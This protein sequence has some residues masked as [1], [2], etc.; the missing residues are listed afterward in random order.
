MDNIFGAYGIIDEILRPSLN[1]MLPLQGNV[2]GLFHHLIFM[3]L[4]AHFGS[5]LTKTASGTIVVISKVVNSPVLKEAQKIDLILFMAQIRSRNLD[6][7][8]IFFKI[9]WSLFVAVSFHIFKHN[10]RIEDEFISQM[11]STVVTYLVITCQ[12]G[13]T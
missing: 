1:S 8:N 5:S 6:I 10:I 11:T 13:S 2:I 7:Q 4:T 3:L 12:F 9:N